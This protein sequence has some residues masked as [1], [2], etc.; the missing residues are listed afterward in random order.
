MIENYLQLPIGKYMDIRAICQDE[1]LT[2]IDRQVAILSVLTDMDA[3]ALL[4]MPIMQYRELAGK[5]RFLQVPAEVPRDARSVA[6]AYKVGGM[7]LVPFLDVRKMTT[8]QYVDFQTLSKDPETN[9]VAL[10]SCFLVPKGKKYN[11]G[12]D[13]AEVQKAIREGL[14]VTDANRLVAFF[15]LKFHASMRATLIY[16]KSLL[17]RMKDSEEK[18]KVERQMAEAETILAKSGDGLRTLTLLPRL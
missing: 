10:I 18:R 12:Y 7:T 6:G 15:L 2:D 9:F 5:A 13:V 8:A 14:S 4:D 17:K 11:S 1:S 3:D 16:S